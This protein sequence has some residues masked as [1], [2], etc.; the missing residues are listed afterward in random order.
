MDKERME[1]EMHLME[2][3]MELLIPVDYVDYYDFNSDKLLDE[4]IRVL[5]QVK[6]GKAFDSIPGAFDILEN[7][8]KGEPGKDYVI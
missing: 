6:A 1:K 5:E 3:E 8:P 4:K 7:Y 2:L